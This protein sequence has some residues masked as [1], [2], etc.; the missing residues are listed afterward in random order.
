MHSCCLFGCDFAEDSLE[1]Y[2][3]C[4]TIAVFARRKLGL[5]MRFSRSQEYWLLTAPADRD[6]EAELWWER[7]ALLEYAVL[8]TTNA[9]RHLGAIAAAEADGALWQAALTGAR[10]SPQ[11]LRSLKPLTTSATPPS[12]TTSSPSGAS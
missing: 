4:P 7:L 12:A 1:H 2:M 3:Q 10:G 9:A 11:L 6:T 5:H 8:R